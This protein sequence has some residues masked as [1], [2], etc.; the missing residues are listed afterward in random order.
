MF[1]EQGAVAIANARLFDAERAHVVELV[2]LDRLKSEFLGL[3]THEPNAAHGRAGRRAGR[4]AARIA[5]RVGGALRDDRAQRQE[6]RV[7]GR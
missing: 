2:E 5:D 4:Q 3:V 1:G 6:P 7:A